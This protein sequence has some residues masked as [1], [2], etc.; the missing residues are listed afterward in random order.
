MLNV[1][2][3]TYQ[4]KQKFAHNTVRQQLSVSPPGVRR[5]IFKAIMC[6]RRNIALTMNST[7]NSNNNNNKKNEHVLTHSHS[8]KLHRAL[9]AP[10]SKPSACAVR[11]MCISVRGRKIIIN[12]TAPG[13]YVSA[14]SELS[15]VKV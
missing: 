6:E 9:C 1:V 14:D 15:P 7:I 13:N 2:L 5:D 8:K 3:S 12:S 11:L 10:L 4:N